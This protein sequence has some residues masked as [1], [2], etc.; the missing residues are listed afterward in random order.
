[1]EA[2]MAVIWLELT[3]TE[4]ARV[5]VNMDHVRWIADYS[6][7]STFLHLHGHTITVKEP[8]DEVV[9]RIAKVLST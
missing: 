7:G 9:S 8:F 1:M 2:N 3:T 5:Q 4:S 6:T